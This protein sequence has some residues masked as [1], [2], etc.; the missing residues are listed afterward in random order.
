MHEFL[1]CAC[2]S[3]DF[4]QSQKKFARSYDGETVTFRNSGV[5][6]HVTHGMW[7]RTCD[8]WHVTHDF[9]LIFSSSIFFFFIYFGI[10][11]T[12][13][14]SQ[15]IQW[16]PMQDFNCHIDQYKKGESVFP[17]P[18][19]QKSQGCANCLNMNIARG[20]NALHC[21]ALDSIVL[22]FSVLYCTW[23][24]YTEIH[25]STLNSNWVLNCIFSKE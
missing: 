14:T 7:H 8:T 5:R 20:C 6:L 1:V 23:M 19:S 3:Q 4:A 15:E 18:Y 24:L 10:S 9:F 21:T 13:W 11:A 17:F 25:Y 12:I 16:Y 2:K 22:Y